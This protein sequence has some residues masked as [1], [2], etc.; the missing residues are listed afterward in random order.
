VL[1]DLTRGREDYSLTRGREDYN[2]T[3]GREDYSCICGKFNKDGILCSHILKI[4]VETEV[5][6][7]PEKYI[8]ERWMKHE[9]KTN[10]KRVLATKAIDDIL[11]FN[12]L[13]RKS[14]QLTLKGAT[15][16]EAMEYLLD[17]FTRI[18]KNLYIILSIGNTTIPEGTEAAEASAVGNDD[19]QQTIIQRIQNSE[20]ESRM[21]DLESIKNKGRPQKPKRWKDIVVQ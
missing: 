6:K 1:I 20:D 19:T 15:K 14:T 10:L 9:R 17:E 21:Q 3:R 5:S 2:L 13:S 4:L 18:E 7:I 11:R 16:E 12:V 8:I